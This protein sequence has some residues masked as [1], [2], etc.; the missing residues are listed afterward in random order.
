MSIKLNF[1]CFLAALGSSFSLS[2]DVGPGVGLSYCIVDFGDRVYKYNFDKDVIFLNIALDA[3]MKNDSM[4]WNVNVRMLTGRNLNSKMVSQPNRQL[5]WR[6]LLGG[7]GIKFDNRF[8]YMMF[9]KNIGI[10]DVHNTSGSLG[11]IMGENVVHLSPAIMAILA[12]EKSLSKDDIVYDS[13]KYNAKWAGGFYNVYCKDAGSEFF[14]SMWGGISVNCS[15]DVDII[16]KDSVIKTNIRKNFG[17]N[18]GH[19]YICGIKMYTSIMS[20]LEEALSLNVDVMMQATISNG[21]G[22][23]IGAEPMFEN[24]FKGI[25]SFNEACITLSIKYVS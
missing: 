3:K 1:L 21:N 6:P 22:T 19:M 4:F 18:A 15:A 8:S 10:C 24:T 20:L 12:K 14:M 11:V 23:L 5:S 9:G 7:Y 16:Y 13:I 2:W 25:P 17:V